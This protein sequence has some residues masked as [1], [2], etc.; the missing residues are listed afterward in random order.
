ME[1][2]ECCQCKHFHEKDGEGECRRFPPQIIFKDK[3][4]KDTLSIFPE[5][6]FYDWC[7]EFELKNNQLYD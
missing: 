5:V 4:I 3:Y 6:S 1:E 2:K 7:G